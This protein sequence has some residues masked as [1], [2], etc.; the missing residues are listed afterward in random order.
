VTVRRETSLYLDLVRVLAALAVFVHNTKKESI[1]FGFLSSFGQFGNEAV[2]IFFVLSGIV[3]A[4]VYH[5]RENNAARY[6]LARLSRLWSVIIPAVILTIVLDS[7][8]SRLAPELYDV[9]P[10]P[11]WSLDF[12]SVWHT[13][14]PILF[15]NQLW[16]WPITPGSNA[17]FWSIGYEAWYY[18]G[19]GLVVFLDGW[20]RLLC[21]VA[22]AAATGPS[23]LGMASFWILGVAIYHALGRGKPAL[24]FWVTWLLTLL[25]L[26]ALFLVKYKIIKVASS[27]FF[28]TTEYPPQFGYLFPCICAALLFGVNIISFDRIS[29]SFGGTGKIIEKPVRFLA[30]RT[31]SLYLY[32]APL[33]FFWGACVAKVTFV[34][35]RIATVY[36]GTIA[37]VYLLAQ[38]SEGQRR[39]VAACLTA[40]GRYLGVPVAQSDGGPEAVSRS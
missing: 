26:A 3:I 18:I 20:A 14:A 34:P 16:I 24:V 1:T 13:V 11:V 28:G 2:I 19:F 33:V 31:F 23:I 8:G 27:L 4:H 9:F 15:A 25:G 5:A 6:A 30:T 38:V 22:V 10:S 37:S 40:L 12:A 36:L 7:L 39:S 35:A 21:L 17:P 32:H 29:H